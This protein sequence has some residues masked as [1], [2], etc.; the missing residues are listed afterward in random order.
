MCNP[1]VVRDPF[2]RGEQS[3]E[4]K[5]IS[6]QA[7]CRTPGGLPVIWCAFAKDESGFSVEDGLKGARMRTER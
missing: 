5:W 7:P 4:E 2:G 3:R 1:V 6:F